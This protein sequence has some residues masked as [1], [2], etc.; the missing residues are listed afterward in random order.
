MSSGKEILFLSTSLRE[1]TLT[2]GADK[3]LLRKTT[4]PHCLLHAFFKRRGQN[5][6][7]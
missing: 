6:I 1:G 7:C 4:H 3:S 5:D 2:F